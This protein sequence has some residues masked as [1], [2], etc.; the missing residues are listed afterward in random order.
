MAKAKDIKEPTCPHMS[1]IC[2]MKMEI[3]TPGASI[4][5]QNVTDACYDVVATSVK[6]TKDYI[7]YG[8]GFSTVIPNDWEVV[9]RPRSSI[10]NKSLVLVNS[11]GT[12][13]SGYRDE[14][15]V[16]FKLTAQEHLMLNAISKAT[17][18]ELDYYLQELINTN[19][20]YKIGDR[21]AQISPQRVNAF[22]LEIVT[23][24]KTYDQ[25]NNNIENTRSGGFGS[26]GE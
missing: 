15:K 5:Q 17:D 25:I 9:I 24:V 7:E 10:R 23:S 4:R 13:D 12:I 6:L 21:I 18:S 3:L 22:D 14:W 26:T 11:P 16:C 20:I 2:H 19:K 1:N 8:L